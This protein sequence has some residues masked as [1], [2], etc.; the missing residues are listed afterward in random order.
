MSAVTLA[1]QQDLRWRLQ[2]ILPSLVR[3]QV[4]TGR[5]ADAHS[6]AERLLEVAR[7]A[8]HGV[9]EAE[10]LLGAVLLDNGMLE[11]GLEQLEAAWDGLAASPGENSELREQVLHNLIVGHKP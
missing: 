9:A 8:E 3:L 11:P 5:K 4:R 2:G 1:E 6:T 10:A 7:D